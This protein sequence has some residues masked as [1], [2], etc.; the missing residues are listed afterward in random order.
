MFPILSD[1]LVDAF[2]LF[3]QSIVATLANCP[4]LC[5]LCVSTLLPA[6]FHIVTWTSQHC[7]IGFFYNMIGSGRI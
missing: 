2:F 6:R 4:F 7:Y 5:Y 1:N 3:N